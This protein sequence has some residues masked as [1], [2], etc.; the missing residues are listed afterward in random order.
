MKI[1]LIPVN[2]GAPNAQAMI[3]KAMAP[4]SEPTETMRDQAMAPSADAA[5]VSA[6]QG[7]RTR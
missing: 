2:V 4:R 5:V 3:G 1:G 7:D 6:A